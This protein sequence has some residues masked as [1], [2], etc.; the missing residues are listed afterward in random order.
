MKAVVHDRY[1]PPDVLRVAEVDRP[2]L[3][4]TRSWSGARDDGHA[5]GHPHAPCDAVLLALTSKRGQHLKAA[6]RD[7]FGAPSEVV[8]LRE[9]GVPVPAE[10]EVLVRVHAASTE[11]RGLVLGRREA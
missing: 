8:E 1:R 9:L 11:H 10:G 3:P 7:R 2:S 6:V 5:H 4:T